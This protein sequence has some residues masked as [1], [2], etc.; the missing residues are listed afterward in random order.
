MDHE[1]S[2]DALAS[3]CV[4]NGD[5]I[6][7]PGALDG[8]DGGG[9]PQVDTYVAAAVDQELD[10]IGVEALQGSLPAVH[11]DR[12]GAGPG[13]DVGELEGDEAASDEEDPLR[14][15]VEV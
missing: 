3:T 4:V 14:K 8:C 5:G 12:R 9:P 2:L 10:E 7:V 1:V 11:D 6:A 15:G 13:G